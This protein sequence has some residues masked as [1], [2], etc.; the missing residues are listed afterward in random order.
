MIIKHILDQEL[1][2]A[3][4]MVRCSMLDTIPVNPE[5]QFSEDFLKRIDELRVVT[6]KNEKRK[7]IQK[8]LATVA[9]VFFLVVTTMLFFNT[10]V[11]AAV[12]TWFAEVFETHTVYWFG[13]DNNNSLPNYELTELSD[14]YVCILDEKLTHSRTML[15]Q[16]VDDSGELFSLE[17]SLLQEDSPLRISFPSDKF[18]VSQVDIAGLTGDMYV[19]RDL[20]ESNAL[21]WV[22][23]VNGVVF[24]ITSFLK[25]Q[26][27]LHI[28]KS[29]N[30]VN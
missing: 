17:Y 29:V 25:P 10:E 18:S 12:V 14:E 9:A 28:A 16:S 7:I 8:R 15:F 26:D 11:R 1:Q 5:G 19:S 3:C 27:I 23:E 30:L 13:I 22:D 2:K 6:K 4:A 21:V 24:T 20:N